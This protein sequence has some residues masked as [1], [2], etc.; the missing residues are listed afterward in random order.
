MFSYK[1]EIQY[2]RQNLILLFIYLANLQIF[3]FKQQMKLNSRQLKGQTLE[4]ITITINEEI[5]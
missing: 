5:G 3:S 2:T 4:R 1:T